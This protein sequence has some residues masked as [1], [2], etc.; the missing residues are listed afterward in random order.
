[1]SRDEQIIAEAKKHYDDINCFNAFL[2]GVEWADLH[3][4]LSALWHPA[5]EMPK[6]FSCEIL[7]EIRSENGFEVTYVPEESNAHDWWNVLEVCGIVRW[8][9]ISDL[10][11]KGGEK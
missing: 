3:T 7:Y 4:D 6:R 5:S 9:Y 1:M 11:P 2:H 10:L 8:A